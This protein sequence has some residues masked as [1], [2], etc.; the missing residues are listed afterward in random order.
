MKKS[1]LGLVSICLLPFA[2]NAAIQSMSFDLL[3]DMGSVTNSIGITDGYINIAYDAKNPD[4]TQNI[5]T[6]LSQLV[7]L[8][9][10]VGTNIATTISVPITSNMAACL[11]DPTLSYMTIKLSVTQVDGK[12]KKG[13]SAC[14]I[15]MG[16]DSSS[17]NPVHS[18]K[19]QETED[20]YYCSEVT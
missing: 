17:V 8:P 1:I 7:K 16:V 10:K 2:A 14:L 20:T 3:N 19:L 15:Y 13:D 11:Q 5:T 9:L 4:C 6:P 12:A 18:L